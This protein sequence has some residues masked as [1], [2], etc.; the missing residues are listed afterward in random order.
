[1]GGARPALPWP[2]A[3]RRGSGTERNEADKS[4]Y[5]VL[6]VFEDF[7]KCYAGADTPEQCSLPKEDY[8]ECLHHTKEVRNPKLWP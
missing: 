8:L 6:F 1:M 7:Q 2:S 3:G 4:V 5:V